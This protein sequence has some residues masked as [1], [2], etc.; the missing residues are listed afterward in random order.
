[1]KQAL[2]MQKLPL[3]QYVTDQTLFSS[4]ENE[5]FHFVEQKKK[6]RRYLMYLLI[7]TKYFT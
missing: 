2:N 5:Q 6:K 1:M 4:Q 3:Y 7:T